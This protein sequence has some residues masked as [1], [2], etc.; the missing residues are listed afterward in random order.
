MT[1]MTMTMMMT[2]MTTMTMTMMMMTMM[3][4]QCLHSPTSC[5]RRSEKSRQT[6]FV[7]IQCD[8]IVTLGITDNGTSLTPTYVWEGHSK[9][10][11]LPKQACREFK[12]KTWRHNFEQNIL[13]QLIE[14]Y[15]NHCDLLKSTMTVMTSIMKILTTLNNEQWWQW[16]WRIQL[17]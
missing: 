3:T 15:D 12:R 4:G 11:D 1:T 2:M 10:G 13:A 9:F 14:K 5:M 8:Q 6:R 7:E 17:N 16:W